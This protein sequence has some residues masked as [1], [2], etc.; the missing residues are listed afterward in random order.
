VGKLIAIAAAGVLA[1]AAAGLAVGKAGTGTHHEFDL[2]FTAK[3]ELKSTGIHLV[4]DRS[5]YQPPAAGQSANPVTRM[6]ITLAAGTKTNVDAAGS[7]CSRLTL[8]RR[9]PGGCS[10]ESKIGAGKATLVTGQPAIDP[11]QE[12]VQIVVTHDVDSQTAG[13]QKGV[14]L[15]LTGRRKAI[16]AE[17]PRGGHTLTVEV[18]QF[19]LAGDDPATSPCDNGEAVLTKID[20]K[21]E[22]RS[23][24]RTTGTTTLL[25]R[26]PRKCPR[27]RKWRNK[28]VYSY[29][30]GPT[31]TVTSTSSCKR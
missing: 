17:V 21:M 28:V 12:N 29:R 11:I 7:Q 30:S 3:K 27:S 31:E 6:D 19:C 14:F 15:Y 2:T 18:P 10:P 9:G 1:L 25:V 16:P 22:K 5:G 23:F 24:R 8:E 13:Q 26:T 4:S 20:A